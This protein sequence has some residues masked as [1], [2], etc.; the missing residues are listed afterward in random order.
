MDEVVANQWQ[1]GENL[2]G[3]VLIGALQH[4][5]GCVSVAAEVRLSD[6]TAQVEVPDRS[7]FLLEVGSE[8]IRWAV[9]MFDF[10]CEQLHERD[11]PLP[12]R[13]GP[14]RASF[15]TGHSEGVDRGCRSLR[16]RGS[17]VHTRHSGDHRRLRRRRTPTSLRL[18]P[19][20]GRAATATRGQPR[21]HAL[22]D[23]DVPSTAGQD[24]RRIALM[25]HLPI[26]AAS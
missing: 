15:L 7:C 4:E 12:D 19:A 22:V 3:V 14:V 13:S 23:E 2:P 10:E 20:S 25:G 6:H 24:M 18:T 26:S 11:L 1:R 21:P 16:S 5:N 9:G 8:R 17:R